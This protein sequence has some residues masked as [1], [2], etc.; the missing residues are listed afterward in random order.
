[1]T[2]WMGLLLVL[3]TAVAP[4]TAQSSGTEES[5]RIAVLEQRVRDLE[6]QNREILRALEQLQASV[7]ASTQPASSHASA[8]RNQ[9][10]PAGAGRTHER[11]GAPPA[12]R[13]D[14]VAD[15]SRIR[16]YGF[17][18]LDAIADSSI[19]DKAQ[20]PFFIRSPDAQ[21]GGGANLTLHPRLTRIGL[22]MEGPKVVRAGN[23]KIGGK[24]EVDFQNGGRESRPVIRIRHAYLDLRWPNVSLLAGQ[25]WDLVSPLYPSANNDTLMWNAGN[26][27]DRRP[28]VRLAGE[29]EIGE[30]TLAIAAAVGLTGAVDAQDLD[31][32]GTRDGERAVAPNVQV[33]MGYRGRLWRDAPDQLSAGLWGLYSWEETDVPVAG[34]R[35]FDGQAVGADMKLALSSRVRLSGEGWWGRNLDDFRGGINQGVNPV[36][37]HTIESAGGWAELSFDLRPDHVV[38]GGYTIDDPRDGQVPAGAR[39]RNYAWYVGN[40]LRLGKPLLVGVDYLRWTTNFAGLAAGTDNRVN[41]Y[42]QYE[43]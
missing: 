26:L 35:S 11:R 33:R 29:R 43:F 30:G 1:M 38:Y 40:R 6:R 10:P 34:S 7:S 28:Q 22:R 20:T 21:G 14:I 24:L 2:R 13:R 25:T 17:L 15:H 8:A 31:G 37:G 23:A 19:P 27:G 9:A 39:V 41:A 3:W 12:H 36:T 42:M 32:D 5:G 18:R 4:V 16:L